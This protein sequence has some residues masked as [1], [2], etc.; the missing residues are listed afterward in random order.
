MTNKIF[1]SL[2]RNQLEA[3]HNEARNNDWQVPREEEIK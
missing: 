3:Y 2:P 1:E